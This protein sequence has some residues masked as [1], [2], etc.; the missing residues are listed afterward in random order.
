[1]AIK[2]EI[3]TMIDGIRND[4][5]HS[6]SQL[7][8]LSMD[9][10]RKAAESSVAANVS[11][12]LAE[13]NEIGHR[14]AD[15]RPAMAPLYNM[16]NRLLEDTTVA[17]QEKDLPSLKDFAT[18]RAERLIEDSARAVARIAE[19]GAGL[20]NKGD[21]VMTFSFSSTVMA[22]LKEASAKNHIKVI[23]PRSGY[24]GSGL[25]T[26][27]KLAGYGL[28]VTLIDDTAVGSYIASVDTV[29]VGADR[30]CAD[31]KLVNAMGTS[32]LA[33]LAGVSGVPFYILCERLK[34]D[35]RLSSDSLELE[36][37]ATPEELT[38]LPRFIKYKNPTYDIT[39]LRAGTIIVTEEGLFRPEE[40]V[41]LFVNK[42]GCK[43]KSCILRQL[44]TLAWSMGSK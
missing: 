28:C 21:T 25:I 14:L 41:N 12:F 33:R 44:Y 20:I 34:F 10:M 5:S 24:G 23:V 38:D 39:P 15:T 26:A 31:L 7:A 13:Q 29:I 16:V 30:I 9:V 42:H 40:I 36:E 37:E 6:A 32:Q 2:P 4:N 19:Y 8:R 17:A 27:R 3:L 43:K 1:M 35:S 22:V 18:R 11:L